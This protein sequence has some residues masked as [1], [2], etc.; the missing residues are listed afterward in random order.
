[1]ACAT[2][3]LPDPLSPKTMTVASEGPSRPIVWN[4]RCMAGHAPYNA[5]TRCKRAWSNR[6]FPEDSAD[7][8]RI[9]ASAS[10]GLENSKFS[11]YIKGLPL[12]MDGAIL[13]QD[14][15]RRYREP[16]VLVVGQGRA[17]VGIIPTQAMVLGMYRVGKREAG[18]N[19]PSFHV[20]KPPPSSSH[21]ISASCCE[22]T[23]VDFRLR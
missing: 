7:G 21:I 12:Q 23:L 15:S 22:R 11:A 8:G 17:H 19:F 3:S 1:M 10:P 2:S 14:R 6:R 16:S 4:N 18:R 5:P 9:C 20:G 13:S